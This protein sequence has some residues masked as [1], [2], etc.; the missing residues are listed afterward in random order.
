M[1]AGMDEKPPQLKADDI[2]K[3]FRIDKKTLMAWAN[4]GR[5]TRDRDNTGVW[6]Y[7]PES[8]L[9]GEPEEAEADAEGRIAEHLGPKQ[10]AELVNASVGLVKQAQEHAKDLLK[11]VTGPAKTV[12][13]LLSAENANLRAEC[14][15]LRATHAEAITAREE[16]L[17]EASVRDAQRVMVAA[18]EARKGKIVDAAATQI[19]GL[20]SGL[21]GLIHGGPPGS[22]KLLK[23]WD[24]L[25]TE[26]L[27]LLLE[28]DLLDA[29]QKT[30]LGDILRERTPALVEVPTAPN[31]APRA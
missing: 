16:M 4:S 15:L 28:I 26:K 10:V 9:E 25:P 6:R 8:Y 12:L 31:G 23:L 19:P 1:L 27:E 24:S 11:L 13:D 2:C 22:G 5:I 7:D 17:N 29:S 14:A 18:A 30:L 3:R 20:L 21:G